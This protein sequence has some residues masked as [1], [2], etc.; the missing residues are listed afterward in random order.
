LTYVRSKIRH[1]KKGLRRRRSD[2]D[3]DSPETSSKR[4]CA[5][6]APTSRDSEPVWGDDL[7]KWIEDY[8]IIFRETYG[9][10][11]PDPPR[12]TKLELE[13]WV[14]AAPEA[15]VWQVMQEGCYSVSREFPYNTARTLEWLM[16]HRAQVEVDCV[17][18]GI[19]PRVDVNVRA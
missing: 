6:Q 19:V 15:R 14:A 17:Q 2:G 13:K 5:P 16:K 10:D 12:W 3:G 18:Q 8:A 11:H 9:V 1:R 4:R 7:L